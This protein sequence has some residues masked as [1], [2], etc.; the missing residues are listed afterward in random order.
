VEVGAEVA[1]E[2]TLLSEKRTEIKRQLADG[3]Y[4]T[5]GKV[6]ADWT[7]RIIQK[8][9][10]NPEPLPFWYGMT[11]TFVAIDLFWN[12]PLLY[13]NPAYL[14]PL[15]VFGFHMAIWGLSL[16]TVL[17]LEKFIGTVFTISRNRLLDAVQSI[18]DLADLQQ[19]MRFVFS[20]RKHLVFG[21]IFSILLIMAG[22]YFSAGYPG[23]GGIRIGYVVS[24]I[25]LNIING[26]YFYIALQG[27]S[28]LLRLSR[29][30]YKLY[31]ADPSSSEFIDRLTDVLMLGVYIVAAWATL[32]TLLAIFFGGA[33]S[34]V[35]TFVVV[36]AWLPTIAFFAVNQYV[37]ARI[38][39][40]AKWT[41]L[42]GIQAQV[43]K[44]QA[45]EQILSEETLGHID[46]LLD[47]HDRIRATRNSAL[48]I[49]A[50]LNFLN[51]LLLPL[52]AFILA[53]LNQIIE[54]LFN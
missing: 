28:T 6:I 22:M 14:F 27:F 17:A 9:T 7:G 35:I 21:G 34:S 20:L 4:K 25:A 10:R 49:R 11:V 12:L 16:V 3:T 45:Q 2:D 39:T 36:I 52:I 43:E 30:Q 26:S 41:T 46:K 8:L 51:S 44:L 31:A 53:N 24:F 48:N 42:N 19:Q 23:L 18:A 37:L 1:G 33:T 5:L 54:L 32:L 29:Y 13:L 40:N 50:G 38:I 47:Y 15:N